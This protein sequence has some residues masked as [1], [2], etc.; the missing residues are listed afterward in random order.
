MMRSKMHSTLATTI[1]LL[2]L[3]AVHPTFAAEYSVNSDSA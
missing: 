1:L 3:A 2:S